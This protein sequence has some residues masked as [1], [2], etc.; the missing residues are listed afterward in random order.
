M[1][2]CRYLV[3]AHLVTKGKQEM[4]QHKWN[5]QLEQLRRIIT[6]EEYQYCD[7]ITDFVK[8]VYCDYDFERAQV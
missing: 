1:L 7:P 4:Q 6:N 3:A 5:S 2:F 8:A